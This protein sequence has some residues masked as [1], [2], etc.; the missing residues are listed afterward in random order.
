MRSFISSVLVVLLSVGGIVW[1]SSCKN[2]CGSTTCQNGGTCSDNKCVCPTGYTGNACET[3]SDAQTIGTYNCTRSNCSPAVAGVNTWKSSI[4]S[5]SGNGYEVNISNFDN[6]NTT[7]VAT[8]DTANN[9]TIVPATGTYGVAATGKYANDT[10]K[11]QF[12][13]SSAVGSGYRCD[14]TLVKE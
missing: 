11:L 1:L 12:T 7:V 10:M 5:V 14:M 4:T 2:K 6:S 8:V 3:A 13:T 9:I